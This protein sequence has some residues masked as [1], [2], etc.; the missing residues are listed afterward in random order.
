VNKITI[1]EDTVLSWEFDK[2]YFISTYSLNLVGKLKHMT[3]KEVTLYD[4]LWIPNPNHFYE[5]IL[6][7]VKRLD[8]SDIIIFPDEVIVK[9]DNITNIY[10]H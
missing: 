3:D 8:D 9:Q 10:V 2:L 7:G 4:A 1:I 5:A 6:K